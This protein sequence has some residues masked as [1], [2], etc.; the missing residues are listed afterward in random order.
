[1]MTVKRGGS[2]CDISM[3]GKKLEEVKVTIMH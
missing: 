1:M 3:K 2:K